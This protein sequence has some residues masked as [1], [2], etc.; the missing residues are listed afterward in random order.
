M[1]PRRPSDQPTLSFY[2]L[3]IEIPK[4]AHLDGDGTNWRS[5]VAHI[6]SEMLRLADGDR[7]EIA[8]RMS[9]MSGIDVSK[10]ML[11]GWSSEAREAHNIPFYWVPILEAACQSTLL[12]SWLAAKVGAQILFGREALTA[13]LGRLERD[14][15]Q[16][17]KRIKAIKQAMGEES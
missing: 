9:R 17:A 10:H 6:V 11:D 4:P 3:P 12:T 1:S 5:E 16:A 8:A 7:W 15:D 2:R 13:E 14:R